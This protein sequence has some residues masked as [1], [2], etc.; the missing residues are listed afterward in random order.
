[1]AYSS[2]LFLLILKTLQR[3]FTFSFQGD[4][5]QLVMRAKQAA[6]Q[7][8]AQFAGDEH[9]G[10]FSGNGVAGV[11]TVEDNTVTVTINRKPFYAPMAMIQK[12]VQ[13]FFAI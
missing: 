10:N 1:M 8:Q 13:E 9:S 5:A 3:S 11:Y 7:N 6:T 12:R 4:P 2:T